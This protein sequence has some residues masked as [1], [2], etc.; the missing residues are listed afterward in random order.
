MMDDSSSRLLRGLHGLPLTAA[1]VASLLTREELY[2]LCSRFAVGASLKGGAAASKLEL[3]AVVLRLVQ[4]GRLGPRPTAA[5]SSAVVGEQG[6]AVGGG[7]V[8]RGARALPAALL[9]SFTHAPSFDEGAHIRDSQSVSVYLSEEE[10]AGGGG[11]AAPAAAPLPPQLSLRA[12]VAA[13]A[14]AVA[15]A[16]VA[17]RKQPRSTSLEGGDGRK[18]D[19]ADVGTQTPVGLQLLP[20]ALPVS[21]GTQTGW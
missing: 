15:A 5:P 20:T 18:K 17:G 8:G 7:E 6:A 2:A 14:Q 3:G 16:A 21:V 19:G 13:T 10:G 9:E 12:V 4:S 1:T 11:G